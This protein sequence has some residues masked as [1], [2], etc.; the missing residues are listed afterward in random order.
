MSE[1]EE[2]F[3]SDLFIDREIGFYRGRS[4]K[5]HYS[6]SPCAHVLDLLAHCCV[7]LLAQRGTASS[8]P[9]AGQA[10]SFR[11]SRSS[12]S[13]TSCC[14]TVCILGFNV[15]FAVKVYLVSL[16]IVFLFLLLVLE[17][18]LREYLRVG[19]WTD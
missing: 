19:T 2:I 7:S 10:D 1:L 14:F 3:L 5:L 18:D 17:R 16:W 4:L 6:Q 15:D 11:H 8:L 13:Y 9:E 12:A